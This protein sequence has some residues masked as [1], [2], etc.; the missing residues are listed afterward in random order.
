MPPKELRSKKNSASSQPPS[1]SSG[2]GGTQ[3]APSSPAPTFKNMSAME[4]I[5]NIMELNQDPVIGNMLIAFS[6]KIPT[7][8]SEFIESDKCSP[9]IV[10]SGLDEIQG[11]A[12][13]STRQKDLEEKVTAVLDVLDLEC[14]PAEVYRMGRPDPERPRLVKVVLP[15]RTHWR[16]ALANARLLRGAGLSNVFIRK[17]MTEDERKRESELRQQ[18]RERNKGKTLREWVVYQG[19]LKHVSELPHRRSGNL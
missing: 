12:P 1:T 15:T 8:F 7:E 19:Q 2:R 14:R 9:S 10:T 3:P 16:R 17:S 13:A 5:R 4:L 6:E 18:A 11:A